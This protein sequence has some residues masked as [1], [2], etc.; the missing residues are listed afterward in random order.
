[1]L[2]NVRDVGE[3]LARMGHHGVMPGTLFRSAMPETHDPLLDHVQ[4]VVN[5]RGHASS[6]LVPAGK[7][8]HVPLPAGR[9]ASDR[10]RFYFVESEEIGQWLAASLAAVATR[11]TPSLVHCKHGVDRTGV[12]V[13]TVLFLCGV[14]DDLIVAE[15][16]L[17]GECCRV[18]WIQETLA[19]LRRLD[20]DH[21][22]SQAV[23]GAFMARDRPRDRLLSDAMAAVALLR[24]RA[25]EEHGFVDAGMAA[26]AERAEAAIRSMFGQMKDTLD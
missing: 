18:E 21:L 9:F 22:T 1:M 6:P 10:D 25:L 2:T 4:T 13:A 16:M 7:Q 14:P 8:C 3:T 26:V 19:G 17:S 12:L 23:R 15:Y 24:D 20:M 5:L 11:P